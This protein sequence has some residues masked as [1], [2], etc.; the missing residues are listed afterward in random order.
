MQPLIF[1]ANCGRNIDFNIITPL[2]SLFGA[3]IS[4]I[5]PIKSNR[6]QVYRSIPSSERLFEIYGQFNLNNL[7]LHLSYTFIFISKTFR[8][9]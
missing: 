5:P 2:D 8:I 3:L 1:Q 4:C 6:K 9:H 7:R